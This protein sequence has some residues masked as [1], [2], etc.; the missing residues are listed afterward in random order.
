MKTNETNIFST[1]VIESECISLK[2]MTNYVLSPVGPQQAN[3]ARKYGS[4]HVL[5]DIVCTLHRK[6][7][8]GSY[9]KP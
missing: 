9:R 5:F 8:R 3:W 7:L 4:L 2:D 1:K 6:Q